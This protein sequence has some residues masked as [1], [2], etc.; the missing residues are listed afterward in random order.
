MTAGGYGA[1]MRRPSLL[2]IVLGASILLPASASANFHLVKI[3]EVYPGTPGDPESTF[4]ELQAYQAGQN[5]LMG[6][7]ILFKDMNG[8][9]ID[10]MAF[11]GNAPNAQSQ[12][13]ILMS[14]SSVS[15]SD[16]VKN[17]AGLILP[18][19]GAICFENIDCV[20]WGNIT[21]VGL[22]SLP[23]PAG[24][25]VAPAG[26]PEGS[27]LTRSIA[28]GCATLLEASDDTNGSAADFS[29]TTAES[30]RGN[31]VTPTETACN[32]SPGAD[33]DTV[34][35]RGPKK[36]STKT[37]ATFLFSSP[38]AGVTFECRLDGKPFKTCESPQGY[39]RLGKG[40]HT[41]S[42]RA[43]LG[44]R[45]DLSP[46]TYGWKVKGKRKGKRGK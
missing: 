25:P 13:T 44:G 11:G 28:G 42:V 37:K 15:G 4:V 8:D 7:Q 43:V 36:R 19:G 39:R 3:S 40:R 9:N 38:D 26:I 21:P 16:D 1:A 27:S 6:H 14:G 35:D 29:I 12:R 24:Q 5:Q 41:F 45:S 46:A 32:E 23:S 18:A 30:P 20:A 33:P 31:A 10:T 2:L 34:I 22:A 17:I